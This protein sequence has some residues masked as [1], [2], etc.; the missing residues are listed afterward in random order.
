[1]RII[2]STPTFLPAIGGAELGIHEIYS[3]LAKRHEVMIV[4]PQLS[5]AVDKRYGA[6]DYSEA[7]YE[8]HHP[9]S[10]LERVCPN[11]VMKVL[12]RT[13]ISYLVALAGMRLRRRVDVVNFHYIEPHGTA[14]IVMQRL[15]GTP[16][17]LSLVGRSDVLHLLRWPRRI[18][19]R[20]VIACSD[21]ALP[22]S[23]FYLQGTTS[24]RMEVVPYGVDTTVFS[25]FRRSATL[26]SELGISDDQC[27]LLSVQRLVPI[28]RVDVLIR[29]MAKVIE[30]NKDALLVLVGHGEEEDALRHLA[31]ELGLS[32]NVKFAGYVSS[33][34]LPV[35]FASADIFVFHS[36]LETFGIVFAQAMA[37]GLP[38]VAA[39]T[40]CVPDVVHPD[41][42]ILVEPFDMNAFCD[43]VVSLASDPTRRQTIRRR[44]RTRAEHEFDWDLI[45]AKYEQ[46]LLDVAGNRTT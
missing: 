15:M 12:H 19:A 28:K 45:A 10:T 5:Q 42:G 29:T 33:E 17:V 11:V 26:R 9:L 14:L 8:V 25:P 44:N 16:T 31:A 23:A 32:R 30:R 27:L 3:R 6:Q 39:D 24:K 22:I 35:Y 1:M 4:T 40:S 41:N 34:D 36:M 20:L 46:I 18:Y 38:I 13:S 7:D 2:V 37:S 43:A 21:A